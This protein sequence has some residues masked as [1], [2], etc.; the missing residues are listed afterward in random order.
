MSI[1]IVI[2]ARFASKRFPGKPLAKIAGVEM[3]KRVWDITTL[4][5]KTHPD[6]YAVVATDDDRIKSFC[7]QNNINYVMTSESCRTGTERTAEALTKIDINP[8]FVINLQGDNPL[9]PPWFIESMLEC[10]KQN[11]DIE[12]ITPYVNLKWSELDALRK[13]KEVSPFSGTTVIV[14]KDEYAIWFSKNIIPAI[15]KEEALRETSE[16]SPVKRHIGL[17]GYSP[18]MLSILQNMEATK[19]EKLEGLE[20]LPI[21]EA[22]YKIKMQEVDYRDRIGMSG[23]DTPE[24]AKKAEKLF[25]EFGEFDKYYQ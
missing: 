10:V 25:E 18:K 13:Q 20:Q 3:L 4:V 8:N 19:Y 24:D 6:T 23:V 14:D 11:P 12:M 9:C 16:F 5:K 1:A 22:G 15:R 17:Y 7:E 2:P 21:L